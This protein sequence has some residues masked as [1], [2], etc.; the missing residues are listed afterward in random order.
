MAGATH[1][2]GEHGA[3]CG[4]RGRRCIFDGAIYVA[5]DVDVADIE[6]R[7]RHNSW[8]G[9]LSGARSGISIVLQV[10]RGGS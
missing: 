7:C 3:E 8:Q 10:A 6:L 5:M 9:G 4:F 2:A 1:W